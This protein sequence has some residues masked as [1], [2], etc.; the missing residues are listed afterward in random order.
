MP[1]SLCYSFAHL[2]RCQ[3]PALFP[4]G[5]LL[6]QQFCGSRKE[7][8][9]AALPKAHEVADPRRGDSRGQQHASML[10]VRQAQRMLGRSRVL[11]PTN[12]PGSKDA[13]WSSLK[14]EKYNAM[15]KAWSTPRSVGQLAQNT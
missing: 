9:A 6:G 8:Q 3:L 1:I 5:P 2:Q 14:L 13:L 12:S 11:R 4:G 15:S 10:C 7:V